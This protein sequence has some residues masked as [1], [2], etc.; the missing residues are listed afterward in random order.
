MNE[1]V[2]EAGGTVIQAE[3]EIASMGFCIGAAMAGRKV[4]TATSG[5]GLSLYSENIGLA[6][7]GETPMVIVNIQRQGPAT[8]SATKGADSDILFARWSTSG[9]L[10]IIALSPATVAEAYELTFRAF[11]FAEKYRTPVFV[12]GNKETGVTKE[13]VDLEAVELPPLVARKR[14]E[15][16]V[17]TYFPHYYQQLEDVP[18][19]SEFGGP[20]V[21][22][23]TT[24]THDKAAYLTTK[25]EL[26]QE[27]VE[28]F[29]AKIER[30]VDDLSLTRWDHQPG[31]QTL[32][33]SYGIT[34]RSA[35]VAVEQARTRGNRVSAL[36]LQTLFPV[37][38]RA[39]RAA[40]DGIRK[41][42]VPEM[43]MGQYVLEIERLAPPGVEVVS[44]AKMDTTLLTPK[45]IIEKGGLL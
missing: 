8:G 3:D 41:V 25:P 16:G 24:S 40:F 20:H 4:M 10:P 36:V 29:A 23:Y 34:S 11:N 44:V 15:E 39:I 26:V 6:I 21:A 14:V 19:M 9:G 18:A 37:P 5:P 22:R 13:T 31:A 45:E 28:H 17:E 7:M 32:I 38:E 30:A 42:V 35:R 43:N 27:M 33:V 1:F 2:P 12:M